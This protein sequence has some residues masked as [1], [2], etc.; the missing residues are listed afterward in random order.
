MLPLGMFTPSNF[1]APA[2][3]LSLFGVHK[4]FEYIKFINNSPQQLS[5]NFGGQTV[6]LSEFRVKDI[7]VP[8][9]FQGTLVITPTTV[10]TSFGHSQSNL[11]IIE[12]Y[13][14]GEVDT[15]EDTA[16][17]QQAATTTQ[18]GKPIFSATIGFGS[19]TTVEQILNI[20]NPANSGAIAEFHASRAYT[21]DGTGPT[22]NLIKFVGADQNYATQV[23]AVFHGSAINPVISVMHC[24]AIDSAISVPFTSIP[25]T[26]N[27]QQNVTQ[28]ALSYPDN[29]KLYPGENL[30]VNINSGTIGHVVR[31]TLK[32]TEDIIVPP[33][34]VLGPN[35]VANAVVND[36]NP[37]GTTIVEATAQGDSPSDV[38]IQNNGTGIFK[39][40]LQA[41]G[42]FVTNL[43]QNVAGNNLIIKVL[44]TA[45]QIQ[46]IVNLTK[47][48]QVDSAGVSFKTIGKIGAGFQ[49]IGDTTIANA[50][51]SVT[52][53][54][55]VTPTVI[56]PVLDG[57]SAGTAII[58][59]NYGTAN[60]NNFTAYTSVAGGTGNVRFF[61]MG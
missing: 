31:L 45:D 17:P 49:M 16:L 24:T 44:N 11:L 47:I 19:T 13:Y 37:S 28:D 35:M 51:T 18:T 53:S 40:L 15:P 59:I 52:H 48:M 43:I 54:L 46:F 33:I 58:T 7:A 36:N 25:E 34:T 61:V 42:N 26:M 6:T 3:P 41:L 23:P 39:G 57:G 27:M 5:I 21:N 4:Y 1:L 9:W 60:V 10:I 20:F 55:G 30:T 2:N 22:V 38:L 56:L 50:G 14:K 29:V 8:R 32:W 12:G